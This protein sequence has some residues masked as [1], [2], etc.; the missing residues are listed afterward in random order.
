M[1]EVAIDVVID[2]AGAMAG[3]GFL[4]TE[5]RVARREHRLA[6]RCFLHPRRR[7][8][9]IPLIRNNGTCP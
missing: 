5:P 8:W 6:P 9:Y 1:F 4:E 7:P 2:V 3:A